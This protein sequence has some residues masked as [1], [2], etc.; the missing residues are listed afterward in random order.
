MPRDM[1][2]TEIVAHMVERDRAKI[3]YRNTVRR[4][5]D[6]ALSEWAGAGVFNTQS[7]IRTSDRRHKFASAFR[8]RRC[9]SAL[10]FS[11]FAPCSVADQRISPPQLIPM[12][13]TSRRANR[14][15]MS[16]DLRLKS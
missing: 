15:H 4:N 3:A 8:L 10:S 7:P 5:V 13:A 11:A 12:S 2:D 1:A 16:S 9:R 6:P 14:G